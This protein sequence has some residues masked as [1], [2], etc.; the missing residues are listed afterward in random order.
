[1]EAPA[2]ASTT[3]LILK[4]IYI[5]N[6]NVLTFNSNAFYGLVVP[7][8][9]GRVNKKYYNIHIIYTYPYSKVF[10]LIMRK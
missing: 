1:M 9:K 8:L 6:V 7:K 10:N 5:K 3:N 2:E 4:K